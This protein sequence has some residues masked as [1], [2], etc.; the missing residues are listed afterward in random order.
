MF[1]S[2]PPSSPAVLRRAGAILLVA[3]AVGSSRPAAAETADDIVRGW[4][5]TL[6]ATGLTVETG[7]I[8]YQPGA[9]TVEVRD[10]KVTTRS[11][12]ALPA[13]VQRTPSVFF[14][15][16]AKS[17][18]GVISAKSIVIAAS[19]GQSEDGRISIAIGGLDAADVV[20]PRSP[21][22]SYDPNRPF[23]NQLIYL[24]ALLGAR[25][26][27]AR[28]GRFDITMTPKEGQSVS[29][30]YD[31]LTL[32]GLA[33]GKIERATSGAGR[34][35]STVRDPKAGTPVD[36]DIRI[37]SAQISGYDFGAYL[38]IVDDA[39]YVNGRGDG[40]WRQLQ[41][42]AKAEG[43]SVT[44]GPAEFS[45]AKAEIGGFELR[46]FDTPISGILDQ[47][48]VDPKY[49]ENDPA[50]AMKFGLSY[51]G[52]F[53]IKSY[54]LEGWN[55]K[56]QELDRFRMGRLAFKDFSGAGLGEFSLEGLD[57]A[58]KGNIIR[59]GKFSFGD[60]VFPSRAAF[61][62]AFLAAT[63]G[64]QVDPQS[65]IP[66]LGFVKLD[67][68]EVSP[69]RKER[70]AL[71]SY[72]LDLAGYVKA[73]PTSVRMTLKNLS[74]P[75]SYVEDRKGREALVALGY[76][77]IDLSGEIDARWDEASTDLTLNTAR[78]SM[79]GAGSLFATLALGNLPRAVFE[80]PKSAQQYLVG[81]L[82]KSVSF[83]YTDDSLADRGLKF[84]AAKMKQS[85]DVL[86]NQALAGLQFVLAEVRDPERN[87]RMVDAVTAFV[88]NPKSLTIS[89]KLTA[90]LPIVQ[91]IGTAQARPQSLP[92]L[93]ML[94]AEANQ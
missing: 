78:L 42:S 55:I 46:Q 26:S 30:S 47:I 22:V 36:F 71:G 31:G 65:M 14:A 53:R 80:D 11:I 92:D 45:I 25:A 58:G 40:V 74:V 70:I 75:A 94:D 8:T 41:A 16:L 34:I 9:D 3:L 15:G 61:E 21:E 7:A 77:R 51:L 64:G 20:M 52:A 49:F 89:S 56:A 2:P 60:L 59:V 32:V 91:I 87:R 1:H 28:I 84:A 10:L 79:T 24:R 48:M 68:V 43:I 83:G 54:S 81:L 82:L 62:E 12:G 37:G 33:D 38:H 69:A 90:A 17:P 63:T 73:I 27:T 67:N 86:R 85:P 23:S 50:S 35:T 88:R 4:L 44:A 5:E 13:L 39:A 72:A 66:T 76:D 57:A 19:A 6:R 18:D 93:L 29:V